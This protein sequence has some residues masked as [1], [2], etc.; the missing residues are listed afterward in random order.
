MQLKPAFNEQ[1]WTDVGAINVLAL[2]GEKR[3]VDRCSNIGHLLEA[4][5]CRTSGRTPSWTR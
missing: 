5:S 1:F 2:D 4:G 3:Q